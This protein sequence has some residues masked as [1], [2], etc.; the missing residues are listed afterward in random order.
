MTGPSEGHVPSLARSAVYTPAVALAGA[1][2]PAMDLSAY[3]LAGGTLAWAL[4]DANGAAR[5]A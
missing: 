4:T 3:R 1:I 5:P 2:G